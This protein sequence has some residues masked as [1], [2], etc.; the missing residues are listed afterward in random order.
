LKDIYLL[1]S[2]ADVVP[3]AKYPSEKISGERVLNLD[4]VDASDE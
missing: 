3:E 1:K 4:R 2:L